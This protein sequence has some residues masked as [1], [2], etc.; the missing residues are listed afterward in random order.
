MVEHHIP[1][2]LQRELDSMGV[3]TEDTPTVKIKK[4]R[5]PEP[6]GWMP[7]YLGEEPPF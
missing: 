7:S 2:W 3:F 6:S 5:Y 1:D 4:N